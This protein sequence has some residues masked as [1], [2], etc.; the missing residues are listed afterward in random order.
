[1]PEFDGAA[2]LD[3]AGEEKALKSPRPLDGLIVLFCA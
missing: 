3:G 2:G 1:M